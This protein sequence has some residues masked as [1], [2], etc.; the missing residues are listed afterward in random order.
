MGAKLTEAEFDRAYESG[1]GRLIKIWE[2]HCVRCERPRLG[3]AAGGSTK[4]A[5]VELRSDGWRIR[6]GYW[7]CPDC[8]AHLGR[9][10]LTE[11]QR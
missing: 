6:Q 10:A 5:A 7:A 4:D 1:L 8:A 3:L 11:E 9:R 2:V